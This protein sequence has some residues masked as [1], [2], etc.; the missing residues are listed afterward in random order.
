MRTFFILE[1]HKHLIPASETRV[2]FA[3]PGLVS[4]SSMAPAQVWRHRRVVTKHTRLRRT[5]TQAMS[6]MERPVIS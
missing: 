6:R 1:L 2:R 5:P 4:S 3:Q